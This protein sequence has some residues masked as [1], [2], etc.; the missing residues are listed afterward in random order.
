MS[1]K[2]KIDSSKFV[3]NDEYVE[4]DLDVLENVSTIRQEEVKEPEP[5]PEPLPELNNIN[6]NSDND[7]DNNNIPEAS[8]K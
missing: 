2:F 1:N 4:N 5:E 8:D 3:F 6:L 7:D